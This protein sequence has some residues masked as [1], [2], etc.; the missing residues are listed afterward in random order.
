MIPH[1]EM[2]A[3]VMYEGIGKTSQYSWTK[4]PPSCAVEAKISAAQTAESPL[5][6]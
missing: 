5:A 1:G 3:D 4:L 2:H 6:L